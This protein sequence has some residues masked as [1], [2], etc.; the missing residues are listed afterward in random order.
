[1]K[2]RKILLTTWIL[3]IISNTAW[4]QDKLLRIEE[5]V[6]GLD[7]KLHPANLIN[8][9]WR[10]SSDYYVYQV[11]DK[12][13][14]KQAGRTDSTVLFDVELLNGILEDTGLSTL[15]S[16]PAVTW[17]SYNEI[18]IRNQHHIVLLDIE[19]MQINRIIELD[20]EATDITL[21]PDFK[22]VAYTKG[23]NLYYLDPVKEPVHVNDDTT[24]SVWNGS[25]YVYRQEF[26][27]NQGIF[28]SPQGNYLAYYR[29]DES[30]VKDYPLV[31]VT[32]RM[33]ELQTIKYPM[34]GMTSEEVELVVYDIKNKSSVTLNTGEP[35]DQYLTSVTW[36]PDEKFIYIVLLN[37]DQD[38]LKLA[39]FQVKTGDL[40]DVLF[41]EK[42]P[43]YVE[44]EHPLVF[45]K[46][47]K[48]KFIWWSER[49]GYNHLYLY[50]TD[51]RL[52]KQLTQ[53]PWEVTD[54]LGFDSDEKN[55]FY[56]STEGSPIERQI[57]KANF[58]SGRKI[59]LSYTPGTHRAIVHPE[60]KYIIDGYS[61]MD[62]PL[63]Y[64]IIKA[65]GKKVQTIYTAGNP[66]KE[67]RLGEVEVF[68]IKAS[69]GITDLYCRMIRP[70]GFDPGKIYPVI[71]YVYGGPHSQL[72]QNR[73]MGGARSWQ[74]FMA[75]KGY[76]AFTLD[77]RGTS[78]RGLDFESIIHRQL[79]AIEVEDQHMG[80][81]YLKSLP[82][83]DAGRIGVHGWSYGGFLTLSMLHRS[84]DD[85]KAGVAGGPV[86]DWKFYEVMYGERYMDTPQ[87]NPE[88]YEK[89]SLLNQVGNYQ[90]KQLIIHGAQDPVVVWQNSLTYLQRAIEEGV[91]V[92]Y[93]VYPTHEHNV[94]GKDRIHLMQK[95]TDYFIEN[96]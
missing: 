18:L 5:S 33:A 21:S 1:M 12:I 80:L 39:R 48:S 43:K 61:S 56:Q 74:H 25:G 17:I 26:G 31:D 93:F 73:W 89:S 22:F 57:F 7:Y 23:S 68:S 91:Q 34:A 62:V 44:P 72:V 11:N 35:K 86:I 28:W 69:D 53:G 14:Q 32:K 83:V 67:Y 71:I 81:E 52:L 49:D 82:Y 37:R 51:G 87:S 24:H 84:P 54:L 63:E 27:I 6:A 85:F 79:G 66:L 47:D 59:K 8:L 13:Y 10:G 76:I 90:G 2:M 55:L 88:G 38:H 60:G 50:S 95:V 3:L 30:M 36:G 4:S 41:E 9:S 40:V 19:K 77:N 16:I 65:D 42:H 75:Q 94:R 45:L 92:D 64:A 78:N 20:S 15:R 46:N 96:L 70:P 29:K 58:K